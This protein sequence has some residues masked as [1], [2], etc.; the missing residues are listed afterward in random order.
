MPRCRSLRQLCN[1]HPRALWYL[2]RPHRARAAR[3]I[4]ELTETPVVPRPAATLLLLTGEP[5]KV[6]M[7][8]RPPGGLFGDAWVFP[9]G[10]TEEG[11]GPL[12]DGDLTKKRAAVRELEEEV[13]LKVGPGDLVYLSR[14]VT[15]RLFPRRYD[16][17]FFLAAIPAQV[18]VAPVND[19]V[20]DAL[21]VA[22]ATAIAAHQAQQWK[23]VLPTLAHLRWLARYPSPEEAVAAAAKHS[24]G[25][26]LEPQL[27]DDGSFVTPDLP[28]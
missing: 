7:V 16:T 1:Q 21:F 24:K 20:T 11:D 8:R 6:L 2:G 18:A 26:P 23:L 3:A 5:V 25:E 9:G 27:T 15:P 28:W 19:E 17:W 4:G 14:W 10:L 12:E 22:P 13:G